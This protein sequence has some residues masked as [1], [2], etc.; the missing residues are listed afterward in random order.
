M[1]LIVYY[2]LFM[3]G[4]G[5]TAYL[6]GLTVERQ[7]GSYPSLIVFLAIYFLSLWVSWQLAVWITKPKLAA[8]RP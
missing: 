1:L 5:L 6:I 4:G 3:I 2:I 7:F 8:P